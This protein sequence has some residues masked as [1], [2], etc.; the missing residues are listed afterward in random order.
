MSRLF[1][2]LAL[3]ALTFAPTVALAQDAAKKDATAELLVK[4]RKPVDFAIADELRLQD[5]ADLIAEKHGVPITINAFAFSNE[6]GETNPADMMVKMPKSKGLSLST[7]LRNVLMAKSATF[8]V[9]KSH[10]EIVPLSRAASEAKIRPD[11]FGSVL[12]MQPLVSAI[13]KEKPLNE[14]LADL[15]EEYDLTIVMAPQAADNRM[16]F[17]NARLLN[18]PADKAIEMLAL[19]ADLRVV[20][21]GSSFFVTSKDHANELFNERLDKVKQK[22][23]VEQLRNGPVNPFGMPGLG[24]PPA[25][26]Q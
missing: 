20:Q 22:L 25:P 19:Q 21:K 23:E 12:L 3:V 14:A 8:L 16:G 17:V 6:G 4:L 5:L 10:I 15:A 11:D 13:Y 9:R 2:S 24:V 7:V 26:K 1:A 18:V